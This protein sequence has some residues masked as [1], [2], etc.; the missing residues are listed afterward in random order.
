MNK[1]IKC[2]VYQRIHIP[3]KINLNCEIEGIYCKNVIHFP[4]VCF[5]YKQSEWRTGYLLNIV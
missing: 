4:L 5:L 2:N 3:E 1:L